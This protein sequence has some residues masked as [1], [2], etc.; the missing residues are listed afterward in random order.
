MRAVVAI[1]FV[2]AA[3]PGSGQQPTPF[4]ED[5]SRLP[6]SPEVHPD[7]RVTFRLLAPKASEVLLA[8]GSLQEAL[9]SPQ[10]LSKDDQ[11]VWSI[12]VGPLEPGLYDYGFAVDGGI[13]TTDP[14]NRNAVER[15]WGHTNFVEVPG[16]L[17]SLARTGHLGLVGIS[18]RLAR[19]YLV[20]RERYDRPEYQDRLEEIARQVRRVLSRDGEEKRGSR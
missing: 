12:T 1:L 16:D 6:V 14:A 5:I 2:L 19:E 10:S 18:E 9:R 11:G 4:F 7:R 13:R 17:L 20:L 8:G 3:Q 15:T